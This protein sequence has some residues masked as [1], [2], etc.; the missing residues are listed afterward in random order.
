M[1]QESRVQQQNR[2]GAEDGATNTKHQPSLLGG[3]F[4]VLV[5]QRDQ[6]MESN[7]LSRWPYMEATYLISFAEYYFV[8]MVPKRT[9]YCTMIISMGALYIDLHGLVTKHDLE[10]RVAAIMNPKNPWIGPHYSGNV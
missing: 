3:G 5:R 6:S 8:Y 1:K 2:L 10:E 7:I 4:V 9:D